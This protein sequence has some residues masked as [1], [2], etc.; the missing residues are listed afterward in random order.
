MLAWDSGQLRTPGPGR[1]GPGSAAIYQKDLLKK[2]IRQPSFHFHAWS[3]WGGTGRTLGAA[4]LG[5]GRNV[6]MNARPCHQATGSQRRHMGH[7]RKEFN[8]SPAPSENSRV[9]RTIG[10]QPASPEPPASAMTRRLSD[11]IKSSQQFFRLD[12]AQNQT[13]FI[14]SSGHHQIIGSSS[15][16]ECEHDRPNQFPTASARPARLP[17]GGIG[18][19]A[20]S[21][22]RP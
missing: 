8:E 1:P 13:Q 20:T 15:D 9:R 18:S 19:P 21:P 6:S 4:H 16:H 14:R 7:G 22:E 11:S 17:T 12:H 10:R 2:M 3:H 5:H